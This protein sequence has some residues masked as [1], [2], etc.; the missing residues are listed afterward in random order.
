MACYGSGYGFAPYATDMTPQLQ[1]SYASSMAQYDAAR[2]KQEEEN[3]RTVTTLATVAACAAIIGTLV[4][5]RKPIGDKAKELFSKAF[6]TASAKKAEEKLGSRTVDEL[7]AIATNSGLKDSDLIYRAGKEAAVG[8]AKGAERTVRKAV[9]S[10]EA[11]FGREGAPALHEGKKVIVDALNSG[12][13]EALSDVE[14][15]KAIEAIRANK[16]YAAAD[17]NFDISKLVES[18]KI[19]KDT[20]KLLETGGKGRPVLWNHI[21]DLVS[22]EPKYQGAFDALGMSNYPSARSIGDKLGTS[23]ADE[24]INSKLS[25]WLTSTPPVPPSP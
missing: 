17:G 3:G 10:V 11:G 23:Q 1:R 22:K 18:F 9:L 5:K 13:L 24:F 21:A 19:E 6:K 7:K 2:K 4:W 25:T 14:V 12:N 20:T 15:K 8:T 16:A